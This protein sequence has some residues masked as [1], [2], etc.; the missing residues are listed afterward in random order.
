MR[1]TCPDCQRRLID[2]V[3]RGAFASQVYEVGNIAKS[4]MGHQYYFTHGGRVA[5]CIAQKRKAGGK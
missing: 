1:V 2:L 4:E 3:N 5:L